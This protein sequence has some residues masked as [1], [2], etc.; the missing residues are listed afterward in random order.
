MQRSIY[1]HCSSSYI[2]GVATEVCTF[3]RPRFIVFY[4]ATF[5][6]L[7]LIFELTSSWYQIIPS[8]WLPSVCINI[9]E[10]ARSFVVLVLC[11]LHLDLGRFCYPLK[12]S[13][14]WRFTTCN[15]FEWIMQVWYSN[16]PHKQLVADK[17]GQYWIR[18]E[19]DRFIF[20]GCGTQFAH[21]ANQY[22]DQ[23]S[24]VR[25]KTFCIAS[26]WEMLLYWL[27]N[28]KSWSQTICKESLQFL[29]LS[30]T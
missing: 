11:V 4:R 17:G 20:P 23:I 5:K 26:F 6:L 29:S 19:K 8:L 24:K 13:D 3:W 7:A 2:N 30:S 1:C 28:E 18:L 25:E 10:L 21:G 9:L 14:K 15:I 16:V 12:S 27:Q 22:L